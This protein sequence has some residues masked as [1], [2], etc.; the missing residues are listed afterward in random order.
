MPRRTAAALP[1]KP[2]NRHGVTPREGVCGGEGAGGGGADCA[3]PGEDSTEARNARLGV[4]GGS[5]ATRS[6]DGG[7]GVERRFSAQVRPGLWVGVG[8]PGVLLSVCRCRRRCCVVAFCCT[9]PHTLLE[10]LHG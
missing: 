5:S 8:V 6:E 7:V 3:R 1:S 9:T 4:N 10:D 2:A